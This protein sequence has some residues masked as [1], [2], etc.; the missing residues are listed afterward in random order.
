MLAALALGVGVGDTWMDWRTRA[1][2]NM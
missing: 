1:Q 2:A